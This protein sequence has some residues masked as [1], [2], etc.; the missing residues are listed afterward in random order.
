MD[1]FS[2]DG[3]IAT[4]ISLLRN[5]QQHNDIVRN[6]IWIS[7]IGIGTVNLFIKSK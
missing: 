5:R 2:C 1:R 4:N 7:G 3:F 6:Q